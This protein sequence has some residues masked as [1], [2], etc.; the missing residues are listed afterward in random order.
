[1]EVYCGGVVNGIIYFR[2]TYPILLAEPRYSRQSILRIFEPGDFD[3]IR[4]CTVAVIGIGGTGTTAAD[5]FA[6][7]GVKRL[8]LVDRDFVSISNLHRQVLYSDEDVGL[9]KVDCAR[10]RLE[11]VNPD[12]KV[13]SYR[14]TFDASN[15]EKF[16]SMADIVFD[17]TDNFTTRLIV[18]DACVKTGKPWIYTSAIET[19]GEAKAVIP[20]MTSCLSCYITMPTHAQPV[21]SEVGVFPSI[22]GMVSSFAFT[23][24][25]KLITGKEVDGAL[26]FLDPWKGEMEKLSIKKNPNC[27]CCGERT[28][29]YL[30]PKYASLG[31]DPLI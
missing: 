11:S 25:I 19:Y 5:L 29:D 20:G 15:A 18:N 22:P 24:A 7:V 17:G 4:G 2:L 27:K 3:R 1:M 21:C 6:R 13:E 28:F 31:I 10:K 16:A 30:S 23:L 9:P 8:I 12:V 14:E 26:F